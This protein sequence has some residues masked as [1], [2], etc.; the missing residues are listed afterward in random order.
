MLREV[1]LLWLSTRRIPTEAK[2]VGSF[3]IWTANDRTW[4]VSALPVR[5][6]AEFTGC[7]AGRV[8]TS[9]ELLKEY[10]VISSGGVDGETITC[11]LDVPHMARCWAIRL[12]EAGYKAEAEAVSG[13]LEA[14]APD[15]A[16]RPGTVI[17]F[18][19][20]R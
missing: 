9:I 15:D 17:Q 14:L 10:D 7:P 12:G 20:S 2:A 13:Y 1:S 5:R 6:V 16:P 4:R 3:L 19:R 11:K 18:P 8:E